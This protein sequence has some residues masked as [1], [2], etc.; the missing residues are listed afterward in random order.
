MPTKPIIVLDTNTLLS[1]IMR[2]DSISAQAFQKALVKGDIVYSSETLSELIEVFN[3]PKFDKY[4]SLKERQSFIKDFQK[5]AI[6]IFAQ[7]LSTPICRDPNDDKY[8][9][10]ALAAKAQFI[11]TGDLDLL[12]L[13][14]FNN[15]DILKSSDFLA[16][17]F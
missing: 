7:P 3:R 1:A 9:A 13:N 15:I 16:F 6:P 8:L 17:P 2:P 10:L 12:V 4:V 11:V 5:A 14:P